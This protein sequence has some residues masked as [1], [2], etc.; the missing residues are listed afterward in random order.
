MA[1]VL[2]KVMR[3]KEKNLEKIQENCFKL[4]F[5]WRQ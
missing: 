3:A 1:F 5:P 4:A 2:K